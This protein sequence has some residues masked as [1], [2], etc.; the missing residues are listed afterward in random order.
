MRAS[1]SK[2]TSSRTFTTACSWTSIC[3]A[4]E[5][6]FANWPIAVAPWLSL[7]GSDAGRTTSVLS[8]R[9]GLPLKQR[10]HPDPGGPDSTRLPDPGG[11]D[12]TRLLDPGDP[13][14]R[15]GC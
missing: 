10:S 2:G 9:T 6:I 5:E 3:S 4:N 12:S 15:E 11:P 14:R 1:S 13:W 8:Q 7:G